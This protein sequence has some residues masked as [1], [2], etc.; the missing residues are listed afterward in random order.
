[1]AKALEVNLSEKS[2]VNMSD[3]RAKKNPQALGNLRILKLQGT[4]NLVT[5]IGI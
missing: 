5:P 1:V 3:K 2:G 4:H